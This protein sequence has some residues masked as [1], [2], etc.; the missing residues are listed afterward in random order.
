MRP[1]HDQHEDP[2]GKID[3]IG[4]NRLERGRARRTGLIRPGGDF[5]D[6]AP[7][8][9]LLTESFGNACLLHPEHDRDG[10]KRIPPEVEECIVAAHGRDVEDIAPDRCDAFFLLAQFALLTGCG[11]GGACRRRSFGD[12]GRKRVALDLAGAGARQFVQFDRRKVRHGEACRRR[13]RTQ[14]IAPVFGCIGQDRDTELL[15]ALAILHDA[16]GTEGRRA[17][18]LG[19]SPL[20]MFG[21]H[22]DAADIGDIVAPPRIVDRAIAD[23][24]EVGSGQPALAVGQRLQPALAQ[25]PACKMR[26]AHGDMPAPV[27]PHLA[28]AHRAADAFQLGIAGPVDPQEGRARGFGEAVVLEDRRLG[29]EIADGALL[30]ARHVLAADFEP[31]QLVARARHQFGIGDQRAEHGGHC[32][33]RVDLARRQHPRDL[34]GAETVFGQ[35]DRSAHRARC[36]RTREAET[37]GHRHA[38]I[39]AQG[40]VEPHVLDQPG[41]RVAHRAAGDRDRLG[42]ARGA[43]CGGNLCERLCIVGREARIPPAATRRGCVPFARLDT[44]GRCLADHQHG[45]F[46]PRP[47][48]QPEELQ[49]ADLVR[50]D[51]CGFA[52]CDAFDCNLRYDT[53]RQVQR[54]PIG[55]CTRR[56]GAAIGRIPR[57]LPPA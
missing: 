50:A 21:R 42:L 38:D 30:L 53:I 48:R 1:D 12:D 11:R 41:D 17:E 45:A 37:E 20:E 29:E 52:A 49:P 55:A 10:R 32:A 33:Q 18:P 51:P 40:T 5:R 26:S 6:G 8:E 2:A 23:L 15:P 27:Y 56:P 44:G 35:V 13:L 16:G 43:R 34:V 57:R 31:A 22:L 9:D 24:A 4:G 19:Q 39:F 46:V 28:I 54:R 36:T 14:R 47:L 3:R 7:F 25:D